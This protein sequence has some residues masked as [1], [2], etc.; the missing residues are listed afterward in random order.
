MSDETIKR[1][2]IEPERLHKPTDFGFN[3]REYKEWT[4]SRRVRFKY[5]TKQ[6]WGHARNVLIFG[7]SLT[8]FRHLL[9]L[10]NIRMKIK[11]NQTSTKAGIALLITVL[12]LFGINV[13]PEMFTENITTII[14][15]CIAVFGAA[16][17]LWAIFKDDEQQDTPQA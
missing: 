12:S 15:G 6:I 13:N 17:A 7:V 10:F 11:T 4:P 8:R 5:R 1:Q 14:E 16:T 3:E 9:T 2:K